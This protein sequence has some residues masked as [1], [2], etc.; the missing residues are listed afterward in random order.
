MLKKIIRISLLLGLFGLFAW[1][2]YYLIGNSKK[3]P[4]V[5][6]TL[7][8]LRTDI[9]KKT[10]ATGTIIPRKEVNMKSQV[11]GIIDALFV[12]PGA[13]IRKGDKIARIRIIPNMQALNEAENRVEQATLALDIARKEFDRGKNLYEKG[14]IP[15]SE[16]LP[17]ENRFLTGKQELSAAESNLAIVKDGVMKSSGGSTN[18]IIHSTISGMVLDVPV[19]EGNSVIESNTFNEGTTIATVADMGE[20][21]FEGKVDESEVGKLK[22]SMD[23]IITVGAI[24]SEKYPA[25]LEYI[26]P[27]GVAE[28]GAIQFLIRA[29]VK[30]AGNNFLRAGYSAN[31][32]VILDE[33]KQ[34]FA[35]PERVLQFDQ[36]NP[37]VEI[38]QKDGSFRKK[39][40]KTGLSD[41]IHIEVL[42]GL[43]EEDELKIPLVESA[44]SE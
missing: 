12:E 36:D 27:K 18:T 7:K 3:Q 37:F 24:D 19:K 15:Q 1:T 43:N 10:I 31:A 22:Q 8:P 26:A 44:G 39:R 30:P 38:R 23:L 35:I 34:A 6:E 28:N 9:A 5:F 2:I 13:S 11:S 4:V 17:L 16:L 29:S 41:G 20:M 40:I 32:D 21:I 33:R 14:V 25:K 42:E